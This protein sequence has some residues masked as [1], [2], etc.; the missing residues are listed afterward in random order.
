MIL[1]EHLAFFPDPKNTY[2]GLTFARR[3]LFLRE[4][5]SSLLGERHHNTCTK[6]YSKEKYRRE[7]R[8]RMKSL[9]ALMEEVAPKQ[10]LL[11]ENDSSEK[12]R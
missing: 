10:G 8:G 12:W 7:N 4:T 9:N 2:F 11:K 6:K 1:L 5:D 3:K